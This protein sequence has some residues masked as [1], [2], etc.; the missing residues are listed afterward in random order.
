M[1]GTPQPNAAHTPPADNLAQGAA[2][3]Q[4]ALAGSKRQLIN[5]IRRE[6]VPDIEDAGAFVT[7]Q[8]IHVLG[9]IR[10]PAT[11]RAI[12]DGVGPRVSRLERQPGREATLQAEK[13]SMVC[14]R[15][16]IGLVIHRTVRRPAGIVLV[17]HPRANEAALAAWIKLRFG[18]A[19]I[20]ASARKQAHAA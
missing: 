13:E 3:V 5:R 7:G 19:E 17:K 1:A 18:L 8:A 10:L 4:V 2:P 16:N 9:A 6:I 11:D 20:Y 15:A 12:V 14:A